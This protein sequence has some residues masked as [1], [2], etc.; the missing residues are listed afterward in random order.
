[1][2][3][4]ITGYSHDPDIQEDEH[5]NEHGKTMLA[6]LKDTSMVKNGVRLGLSQR[7]RYLCIPSSNLF[8][9]VGSKRSTTY[10]VRSTRNLVKSHFTSLLS[11]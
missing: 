6:M 9:S 7:Y 10:P 11:L 3:R 1:M 5:V 2:E 8:M 4:H